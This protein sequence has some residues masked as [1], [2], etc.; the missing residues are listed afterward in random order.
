MG[1]EATKCT[2][3][4]VRYVPQNKLDTWEV[5]RYTYSNGKMKNLIMV[6]ISD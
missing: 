4:G 2:K 6:L 5:Q 3:V 1:A